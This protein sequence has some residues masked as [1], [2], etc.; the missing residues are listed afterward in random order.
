MNLISEAVHMISYLRVVTKQELA[1]ISR[2]HREGPE[3]LGIA[4]V[5]IPQLSFICDDSGSTG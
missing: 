5:N 1:Q 3:T 2:T 4:S